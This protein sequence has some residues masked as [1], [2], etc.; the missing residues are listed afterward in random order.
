MV[1]FF[2]K[3]KI[4][5]KNCRQHGIPIVNLNWV[6]DCLEQW[7]ILPLVCY[8]NDAE[9]SLV[10]LP[11][12]PGPK[13]GMNGIIMETD[14]EDEKVNEAVGNKD[15]D[16]AAVEQAHELPTAE[17]RALPTGATDASAPDPSALP[18]DRPKSGKSGFGSE[19]TLP[20]GRGAT[21]AMGVVG[22]LADELCQETEIQISGEQQQQQQR[23]H[24]ASLPPPPAVISTAG[25]AADPEAKEKIENQEEDTPTPS[26]LSLDENFTQKNNMIIEDDKEDEDD[27]DSA[28]R[29]QGRFLP[30]TEAAYLPLTEAAPEAYI[31]GDDDD[32][33]VDAGLLNNSPGPSWGEEEI[34]E[35]GQPAEK[36][37]EKAAPLAAAAAAA[38]EETKDSLAE[39]KEAAAADDDEEEPGG[40]RTRGRKRK[41]TPPVTVP[42][43]RKKKNNEI[44][45]IPQRQKRPRGR[46]QQSPSRAPSTQPEAA[47]LDKA[48]ENPRR[49]SFRVKRLED[50]VGTEEKVAPTKKTRQQVRVAAASK[51]VCPPAAVKTALVARNASKKKSSPPP[52]PPQPP[53]MKPSKPSTS[54]TPIATKID[55]PESSTKASAKSASKRL[56]KETQ[57]LAA[58][59]AAAKTAPPAA[60]KQQQLL[61]N[62]TKKT[63]AH[64]ALSGMH[65]A[66]QNDMME[67]FS[68]VKGVEITTSL[69]R[70]FKHV[71]QPEF[72]HIVAPSLKRNQKCLAAL[73]SGAWIVGP[74]FATACQESGK[75]VDAEKYELER[76]VAG[77][78]VA[79]NKK[80]SSTPTGAAA[81]EAGVAR[82]WR[83]RR[84]KT[85]TGAFNQ[86]SFAIIA[87][88]L[89]E[90]P[91]KD[92]L[93]AII[94]AGG[95]TV[96]PLSQQADIVIT[97][98]NC[99][100]SSNSVQKQVKGGAVCVTSMYIVDWLTKPSSDL[101]EHVLCGG[102]Q[103]E[104]VIAAEAA[105][106]AEQ[107][108]EPENSIS[109]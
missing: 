67:K 70:A 19:F 47:V 86:L 5:K 33:D 1:L 58:K 46:K 109:L 2:Q 92:D 48:E 40:K 105:R 17:N 8:T 6:L 12:A 61:K 69:S 108:P 94:S 102:G 13:P 25:A 20:N 38:A 93:V 22:I 7:K 63:H 90:P 53:V 31:D 88:G 71:W 60:A 68:K 59:K 100:T 103:N 95:G 26:A 57:Q 84:D 66:E 107:R 24:L 99:A 18:A 83:L 80:S 81:I 21:Q 85:G 51:T 56:K 79:S 35:Q 11:S 23:M 75:L 36:E 29:G 89:D 76:P 32:D 98:K 52:P 72:T 10:F 28:N 64:I 73:A 96:V 106:G 4:I 44:E 37:E 45:P 39:K 15:N 27:D 74:D 54:A 77:V 49:R 14:D 50:D 78:S 101:E 30:P 41:P 82:F 42:K 104:A 3:K 34:E 91:S 55:R 62:K 9:V 43:E 97:G 65:T 16:A 87:R